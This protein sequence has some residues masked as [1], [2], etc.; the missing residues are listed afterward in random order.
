M[1]FRVTLSATSS[2]PG[3]SL[4]H[5][6][7]SQPK[8][9]QFSVKTKTDC[10]CK[11][12]LVKIR[13]CLVAGRKEDFKHTMEG[14]KV[15]KNYERTWEPYQVEREANAS[16]P[17][18]KSF[19]VIRDALPN[20]LLNQAHVKEVDAE[21][22]ALFESNLYILSSKPGEITLAGEGGRH[23][24]RKEYWKPIFERLEA[25]KHLPVHVLSIGGGIGF[26]AQAISNVFRRE[27]FKVP[28]MTVVD[29]NQ[30]A[31]FLAEE[32]EYNVMISQRFFER[33]FIKRAGTL[34][35]FHLG[36]T[37]NVVL[38]NQAVD[39]LQKIAEK[40]GPKDVLSIVMVDKKQFE[41]GKALAFDSE[42]NE[43]FSKVINKKT[44]KHYKT[45]ITS[46][47]KFINFMSKLGLAG[48]LV[49]I[50]EKNIPLEVAFVAYKTVKENIE[51]T[52]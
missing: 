8:N 4:P 5:R 11:I 27:N 37:L 30:L 42:T 35:V 29:P 46:P 16:Q 45:V 36:T 6:P 12:D 15:K 10:D 48:E 1:A 22:S 13:E 28:Q 39:I 2:R 20:A 31:A 38:E 21:T 25:Y 9:R 19:E 52:K 14:C 23:V 43:G 34:Y 49:E 44:G 47:I 24:G 3:I 40:M 50:T 18:C 7:V 51:N 17:S 26:D 41:R 32:V 33:H